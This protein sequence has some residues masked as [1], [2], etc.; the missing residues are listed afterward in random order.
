MPRYTIPNP[1]TLQQEIEAS[2]ERCRR[3][4]VDPNQDSNARQRRLKPKELELRRSYSQEFLSI[5]TDHIEELY[6]YVAGAGFVVTL[7]DSDGYI[8]HMIGDQPL[9]ERMAKGNCV[10]GYRWTEEDVGTSVISLSIARQI[11]AQIHDE[12]HFCLRGHGFTCSA[13][14]VFDPDEEFLGVIAMSGPVHKVHPHTLG[15]VITVSRAIEKEMMLQRAS[16]ELQIRNNYMRSI[17]HSID[18]GVMTIDRAGVIREVNTYGRR[19]FNWIDPLEGT[20]LK[21][22]LGSQVKLDQ[23]MQ[24]GS[25][26]VDREMFIQGPQQKHK[27]LCTLKPISDLLDKMH[28]Y[29]MVF[30]EIS[31]IHKIV[32][33]MAGTQAKF[34]FRDIL[35][36]SE[37]IEEAKKLAMSAAE[38]RSTVLL[39]G[40]TGTGKELFAQAIHNASD[41]REYPF[42][43][44]NC[45]AI[46]KELLESE[47]FGYAEGAFTG[48]KKGG[49]PGKFELVDRGT[50]FLDEIGDMPSD[51]QVKLLRVLQT[52]EVCRI[53]E[54]FPISVNI[55]IIAATN[56]DLKKQVAQGSFREDLFYRLHVFP[57]HIPPLRERQEDIPLLADHI[58][59]R[60]LKNAHS[61]MEFSPEAREAMRSYAWPGNV[62]EMENVIER[63]VNLSDGSTIQSKALNIMEPS[64]KTV[65]SYHGDGSYLEQVEKQAIVDVV[66][67]MENNLSKASK[68]LGISR[69]TL[70]KKIEKYQ[71]DLP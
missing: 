63:G 26:I 65:P 17:I 36:S 3:F 6:H 21:A 11:P 49:R 20:E 12:E 31:R 50:L 51:M 13:A 58:L 52:G 71:L 29:I 64:K 54:D 60:S 57:I 59:S 56:A 41:R 15:M 16:E 55:R 9:L 42:L 39:L 68:K 25:E 35:G 62:R 10:P 27:I 66:Q 45:G 4:N 38:R 53:G 44:I 18:S 32:H 40:E 61:A 22:L 47:L 43:A 69:S 30:H 67:E 1:E 23:L 28:G 19:I 14:P 24:T 8:L 37:A 34:T 46:P 2:H 48:A 5:A 7:A 33:A 70:Y